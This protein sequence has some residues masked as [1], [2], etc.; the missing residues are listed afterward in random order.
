MHAPWPAPSPAPPPSHQA[1]S[2]IPVSHVPS[3][4]QVANLRVTAYQGFTHFKVEVLPPPA[5]GSSSGGWD[6]GAGHACCCSRRRR[7]AALLAPAAAAA[8]LGRLLLC[9][10]RSHPACLRGPCPRPRPRPAAIASLSLWDSKP[11][12]K[13]RP[14]F[15]LMLRRSSGHHPLLAGALRE[16]P[17]RGRGWGG[18]GAGLGRAGGWGLPVA[19]LRCSRLCCPARLACPDLL[20]HQWFHHRLASPPCAGVLAEEDPKNREAMARQEN[21][22]QQLVGGWQ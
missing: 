19:C 4:P 2:S 3:P 1:P 14:I 16:C 6:S 12:D 10:H 22:L 18:N 9:C 21:G 11:S 15:A 20:T 13:L 17:A 8:V 7:R 5:G